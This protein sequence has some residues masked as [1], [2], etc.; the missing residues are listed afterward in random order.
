VSE[1]TT[2]HNAETEQTTSSSTE[3]PA[4]L[5]EGQLAARRANA[6]KSTGPEPSSETFVPPKMR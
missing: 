2:T 4:T 6:K 1:E 3:T 5:N